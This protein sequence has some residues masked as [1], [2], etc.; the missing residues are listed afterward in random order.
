MDL[1][2][3]AVSLADLLHDWC[4]ARVVRVADLCKQVVL[5]LEVQAA[6]VPRH[7]PVSR[8]EVHGRLDLVARPL[9][10]AGVR[11]LGDA[12]ELG[13]LDA[14]CELERECQDERE[15]ERRD[16]ERQRDLPDRMEEQRNADRPRQEDELADPE[17]GELASTGPREWRVLDAPDLEL[18][19]V[20]DD[21]PFNCEEPVERPRI[22][23][24]EA[25]EPPP[26]LIGCEPQERELLDVAVGARDVGV[27]VM[28]DVVLDPPD[29]GAGADEVQRPAHPVVEPA[30]VG[31]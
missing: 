8:C 1:V 22:D 31:I 25:V 15:D 30:H 29:V 3:D 12:R 26:L 13:L 7:K 24:L 2:P 23:V 28:D 19:E 21:L 17:A 11:H 9:D 6:H 14:V 18:H 10:L 20:T 16:E 4:E 5:D 27:G